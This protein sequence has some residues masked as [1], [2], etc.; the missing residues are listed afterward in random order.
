MLLRKTMCETK[1]KETQGK[2]EQ[3]NLY[4]DICENVKERR[5]KKEEGEETKIFHFIV[6]EHLSKIVCVLN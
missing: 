1:S 3:N 5:I 2:L 4:Y 6:S